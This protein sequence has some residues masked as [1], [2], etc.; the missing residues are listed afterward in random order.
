M[1]RAL[2]ARAH[3]SHETGPGI[4]RCGGV[5][6]LFLLLAWGATACGPPVPVPLADGAAQTRLSFEPE[7]SATEVASVVHIHL[8]G[9]SPGAGAPSLFE[10]TLSSYYLGLIKQGA[11]PDALLA[12]QVPVVSWRTDSERIVAPLQPLLAGQ[13]SLAGVSGLLGEFQVTAGSPLLKRLWPPSGSAGSPRFA[14]YCKQDPSDDAPLA[15]ALLFDPGG[16]TVALSAGVEDEG[17]FSDRCAHIRAEAEPE[18]G[19]TWVPAPTVGPWAVEPSLFSAPPPEPAAPLACSAVEVSFGPGCAVAAD[20]R[21]EVRTPA[22]DVLWIVH[23]E[24]GALVEVTPPGA[25]LTVSGLAPGARQHVWG[26]AH[27]RAGAVL[28]LDLLVQTAAARPRPILNE[29][30]ADPLGPE[31]ASEWVE[32]FNDGTLAVDLSGYFLQDGGGRIPL[33]HAFLD[34]K[35]Y[36]LLVRDDFAE[37]GSD[38]PPSPGTLLIHVPAL[39]KSGLSNSGERLA[40]LDSAGA[41]CSVLPALVGKPGQSL[42]RLSPGSADDDPGAFSFGVPTPGQA[43]DRRPAASAK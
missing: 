2:R 1:P 8:P 12:R 21:L 35:R 17:P 22:R 10:G 32:L 4:V 9:S 42:A 27:E 13:Y 41:P 14:V 19:A 15:G 30:L 29:V 18:A 11:L 26:S 23:T 25:P 7:S 31:P 34:P 3:L 39:G 38:E 5:R 16:P 40:L 24:R 43:N 28:S 6:F 36:A 20:D 33:P 37:N